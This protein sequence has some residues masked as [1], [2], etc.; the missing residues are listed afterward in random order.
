MLMAAVRV[1]QIVRV[2]TNQY[3]NF[4]FPLLMREK[5][6]KQKIILILLPVIQLPDCGLPAFNT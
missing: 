5:M 6:L 3:Y 2:H 1:E 4:T